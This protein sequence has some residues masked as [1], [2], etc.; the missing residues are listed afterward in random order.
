MKISV[1]EDIDIF[2]TV[3]INDLNDFANISCKS[4]ISTSI[5]KDGKRNISNF[6]SAECIGLDIDNDNKKGTPVITLDQARK[7]FSQYKHL[8]LAS[9]SH[10]IE[11]N[12]IV[13]ERFRIILF[14]DHAITNSNDF[15]CT[16]FWLKEQFPWIDNQCKDPSR[17]W[18]QH[19]SV[20]SI[21]E[22]GNLI[23]PIKYTEPEKPT[24]EGRPVLPGERGELSKQALQF[25][26][27]GV[28]V[29]SRNG[30]VYKIAREFQQALYDYDETESRILGSLNRN[31]VITNDFKESEAKLAIRS[32]FS[33]DAKHAPRILETKTRAFTYQR[34]GDI[35]NE[36]DKNDDWLVEDLLIK[37]G[38]SVV[39]GIPKIG[40][41]TLVR[42]LEKSILRGE[43]FLN[44]TSCKGTVV[45][46]SFDEKAKTAK[47]H[48]IKLGLNQND[49]MVLHFGTA[50][51]SSYLKEL[52]EDLIKIKPSLVV[53]DTLF[54]MVD[55]Q[56]VNS[57]GPIKRQLSFFS[58]LAERTNC[59]IMFIHHQ[60]KPNI[61]YSQGSGHSVL[62]STAIFGSVDACIIFEEDKDDKRLRVINVKGRGVEDFKRQYLSF[63]KDSMTYQIAD[64]GDPF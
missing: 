33:K 3:E 11:K 60:N 58:S 54:D 18:Y 14:P 47:R 29:G 6:I 64:K 8:I 4:N 38:M 34:W 45:H 39:V 1:S 57:Y 15:Y 56:D 19:K 48:Y 25:L 5:F 51:N 28:E 9:K 52:E 27:F 41:T 7:V 42:Q 61:N 59:H 40:K 16:W 2:Q 35:L 37:G 36:P 49:N 26:E 43:K 13:A 44:K 46:Y 32:A 55:V 20:L 30:T 50:S 17:F 53:V 23:T 24:K 12:G 22:S 10:N 62:G 63:N 21:N 31:N